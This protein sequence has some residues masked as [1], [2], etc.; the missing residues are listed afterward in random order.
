MYVDL[1]ELP[2]VFDR[3]WLWS[4]RLPNLAWF[5]RQDYLDGATSD[6]SSSIR[7]LVRERL[8]EK[9]EGPIRLLTH[10][11]YFGF[12]INPISL[13]FCYGLE[14]Q[15]EFIVVEVTNTPWGEKHSYV[16][17]AR[18]Q[19]SSSKTFRAIK[20]LHVSPFMSMNF[21][22][23]FKISDPEEQLEV[24]IQ[25]LP[26]DE[27]H[28]VQETKR[29]VFDAALTLKRRPLNRM[30]L[31]KALCWYPLMTG[32]VMLAIYWQAFRLWLKKVPFHR[33]PDRERSKPEVVAETGR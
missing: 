29:S 8:G 5:R 20:K 9:C 1:D 19:F 18:D 30:G 4:A 31:A 27:N 17:D 12:V 25:N 3:Y 6:L 11:R 15:V 28:S 33:H 13:Y 14:Q 10:F 21:E 2:T 26:F 23:L 16:F 7:R 24:L 22:Y 32:Q